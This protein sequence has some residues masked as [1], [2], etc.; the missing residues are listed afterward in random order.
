MCEATQPHPPPFNLYSNGISVSTW[1]VPTRCGSDMTRFL[2]DVLGS[3]LGSL[4][5]FDAAS[6]PPGDAVN[7]T[8]TRVD[9]LLAADGDTLTCKPVWVRADGTSPATPVVETV[10]K[11]VFV[12]TGPMNYD[13]RRAI[14][15]SNGTDLYMAAGPG[16]PPLKSLSL[17]E[18]LPQSNATNIT[19]LPRTVDCVIRARDPGNNGLPIVVTGSAAIVDDRTGSPRVFPDWLFPLAVCNGLYVANATDNANC[20]ACGVVCPPGSTCLLGSCVCEKLVVDQ[21][22]V[23]PLSAA[24]NASIILIGGGGGAAGA[25]SNV[26]GGDFDVTGG[27]GGGGGYSAVVVNGCVFGRCAAATAAA[28]GAAATRATRS[29]SILRLVG[30]ARRRV[31]ACHAGA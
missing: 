12:G 25:P 29:Q 23:S 10:S 22:H 4:V 14:Y 27:G 11:Y 19:A 26:T 9:I 3:G 13:D 28:K 21:L 1:G 2:A 31:Q 5:L 20:G 16:P 24:V 15:P 7:N 6:W 30:H 17:K 8:A 18:T